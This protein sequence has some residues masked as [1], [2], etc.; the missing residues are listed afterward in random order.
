MKAWGILAA[1]ML[2]APAAA[3]T[4]NDDMPAT[5]NWWDKVGAEFFSEAS[6]NIA[7]PEHEIRAQWTALS[8]DDQAAVR[9]RCAAA[10]GVGDGAAVSLQEGDEDNNPYATAADL[11]DT[12]QPAV[13]HATRTE[14]TSE[15]EA[16]TTT[17][18]VDG[19]EKQV[20]QPEAGAAPYTGLAGAY[21]EGETRMV[22]ICDLIRE[23]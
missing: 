12:Q 5:E 13:D 22:L 20:T 9:A 2:A 19:L 11:A 18:S 16:T 10:R 14:A 15:A 1:V 3:Q 8:E 7:R 23:L 4:T 21:Q 6:M 17:G